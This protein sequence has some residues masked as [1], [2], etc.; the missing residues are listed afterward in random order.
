MVLPCQKWSYFKSVA[1]IL[2]VTRKEALTYLIYGDRE[3]LLSL[4]DYLC[5]LL[6]LDH[7]LKNELLN[8]EIDAMA[9][10]AL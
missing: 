2:S 3:L 8:I 4:N 5:F 1:G 6:N 9:F 10:L 7:T